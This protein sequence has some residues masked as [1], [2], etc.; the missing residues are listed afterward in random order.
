[1]A[2]GYSFSD[3]IVEAFRRPLC[4][5]L[6]VVMWLTAATELGPGA[7]IS[8]VYNDVMGSSEGILALVW[9][10]VLMYLLRQFG[11]RRICMISPIALIALTAPIAALGLFLFKFATTPPMF[12]LAATLLYVGVCFWWPTM[13]GIASERL[14]RTGALGLAI[15]GGTG[16][17]STFCAGP[18]MGWINDKYD[19]TTSLMVWAILPVFI[20]IIFGLVYL[21]DRAKGGYKKERLQAVVRPPP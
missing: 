20:A 4:W 1:V 9:G 21:N 7:W 18:I 10:S 12:F 19:P 15:I 14:P 3:M 17:F 8:N 5:I 2:C 13:L 11:S 6:W 16:S